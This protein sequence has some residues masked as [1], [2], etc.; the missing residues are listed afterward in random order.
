MA[1]TT[2]VIHSMASHHL[3]FQSFPKELEAILC[4]IAIEAK[5]VLYN[6]IIT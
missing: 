1:S 2:G 3:I 6:N 5:E 4:R